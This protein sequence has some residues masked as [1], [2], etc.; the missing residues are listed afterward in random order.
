[1]LIG[2][3]LFLLQGC[4]S[5][6][7]QEVT[8]EVFSRTSVGHIEARTLNSGDEIEFSVEVSGVREVPLSVAKLDY[9]GSVTVPLIGSVKLGSLTL[10]QAR[11]ALEKGY[12]KIF[13]ATPLITL[14]LAG[15]VVGEW[16]YVTVLGLVRSPGRI[17]IDSVAG[18]NLSDAL[19]AAGGFDQSANM[20]SI[21]VTRKTAR[22]ELIQCKCDI[23]K[24]GLTGSEQYDL[25]L[26]NGDVVYVPERL[27]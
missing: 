11:S 24:L 23:T 8:A 12:G 13:V 1:M 2:L 17:P 9:S 16:G 3:A 25:T 4:V 22:G 18:I 20:Q 27:F 10:A 7:T 14:R 26:F 15:E 21:I 19:H 5:R 6:N